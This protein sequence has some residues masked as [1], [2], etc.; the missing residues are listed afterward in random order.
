MPYPGVSGFFDA[1]GRGLEQD[2]APQ[3]AKNAEIRHFLVRGKVPSLRPKTA[4]AAPARAAFYTEGRGCV[5]LPFHHFTK[6]SPWKRSIGWL[7]GDSKMLAEAER[8]I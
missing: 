1:E 3:C 7:V 5:T 2:G 4:H 6:L 8:A